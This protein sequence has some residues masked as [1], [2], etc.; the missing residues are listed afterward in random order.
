MHR[1]GIC[2]NGE[3]SS[4]SS[5]QY[6]GLTAAERVAQRRNQLL[7]VGL[8]ILGNRDGPGELTL[9]N[10]CQQAGLSQRYFYE[11]FTDRDEFVAGIYDWVDQEIAVRVQPAVANAPLEEKLRAGIGGL[12]RA[13]EADR[14]L[15]RLL[16]GA[17]RFDRVL[18]DKRYK[19]AQLL[20]NLLTEYIRDTTPADSRGSEPFVAQFLVGG[21]GWTLCCWINGSATDDT[22]AL[23]EN[24]VQLMTACWQLPSCPH[25]R[26]GL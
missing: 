16:Y 25:V 7:R 11:S 21:V 9:R 5:R 24:I 4:R 2:Q 20:A 22:E 23:I 19:S 8:N 26:S 6:N 3:V 1:V 18:L 14:R 13:I 17:L 12:V 15:G 10:V